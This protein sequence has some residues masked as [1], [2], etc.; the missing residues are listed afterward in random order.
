VTQVRRGLQGHK[1]HKAHKVFLD[2]SV[3]EDPRAILATLVHK[4]LKVPRALRDQSALPVSVRRGLR[5]LLVPMELTVP[6][7]RR[8]SRVT[9]VIRA[10]PVH[11]EL[12]VQRVIRVNPVSMELRVLRELMGRMAT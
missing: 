7:E 1:D 2:L 10:K 9:R 12:K 3:I 8:E 6:T 5:V 4:V 11:L